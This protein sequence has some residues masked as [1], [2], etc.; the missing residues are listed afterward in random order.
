M[1]DGK[2]HRCYECGN[3]YRTK[4][5]LKVHQN[6]Y[7]QSRQS[8]YIAQKPNNKT[9]KVVLQPTTKKLKKHD[10]HEDAVPKKDEVV[11]E[12]NEDD[13]KYWT[14]FITGTQCW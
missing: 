2:K 10:A 12:F 1:V 5:T 6:K 7:C 9:E 3:F 14:E 4:N 13:V 8:A 11:F